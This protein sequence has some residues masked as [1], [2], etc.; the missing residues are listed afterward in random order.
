MMELT[1]N[2]QV[3]Q[4][5]FGIGIFERNQQADKYACGWIAGSEKRCRIPIMR[6]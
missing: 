1:I 4:F 5:K 2:G 6:L 3:Y